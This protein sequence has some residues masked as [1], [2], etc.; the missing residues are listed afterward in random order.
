MTTI[1]DMFHEMDRVKARYDRG[2]VLNYLFEFA[3]QF[4]N[5]CKL[6]HTNLCYE[7]VISW[8]LARIQSILRKRYDENKSL[9]YMTIEMPDKSTIRDTIP[10][11]RLNWLKYWENQSKYLAETKQ[12]QQQKALPS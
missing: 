7:A 4:N 12:W 3:Y 5:F 2:E 9:C 10:Q 1:D 11:E 8:K 6:P